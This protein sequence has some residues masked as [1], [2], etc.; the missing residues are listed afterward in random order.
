[1]SLDEIRE[2]YERLSRAFAAKIDAVP[3]DKW[4]APSPCEGWTARDVVK[5]VAETPSMIFQMA[6]REFGDT[7][8]V[9][10]DPGAAFASTQSKIREALADSDAATTEYDSMFGRTSLAQ[11]IDRFINF[12]LVVH[13]WDLSRATGLDEAIDPQEFDR[14]REVAESFGDAARSPQVLGPEVPVEPG[15]DEQAKLLGFLG[16]KA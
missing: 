8:S 10:E 13:A 3:A 5:H 6:G 9:D 16:R 4:D 11:S 15:A 7:P 2:R 1:M 14:L 12:D